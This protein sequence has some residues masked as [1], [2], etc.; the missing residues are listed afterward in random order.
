MVSKITEF[1][2]DL[3]EDLTLLKD[4]WPDNVITMQKIG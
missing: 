2:D 1:A 3:L 4:N